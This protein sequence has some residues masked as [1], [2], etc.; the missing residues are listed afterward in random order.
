MGDLSAEWEW[1]ALSAAALDGYRAARREEACHLWGRAQALAQDFAPGDPRRAAS[2]NNS[3]LA[4]LIHQ[5]HDS[6]ALALSSALSSWSAALEWVG[7]MSV[8]AM[9]RSSLFHQRMEQ[10]HVETYGNVRRARHR[11]FLIGAIALTRF[12]LAIARLF[13]DE[14]ET[15]DNLLE[16]ALGEREQAF[17]PNNSEV[18]EIARVLSGRADAAEDDTRMALYDAKVLTAIQNPGTDLLDVWRREQPLEMTDTRRLLAA[19]YLTASVHERDF[20]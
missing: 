16:T 2:E 17:G 10:R 5:D 1:D 4:L 3:A 11:E 19:G 12:N 6:A 8:A 14:D 15:A 9:A 13:L 18:A 20:L 7:G